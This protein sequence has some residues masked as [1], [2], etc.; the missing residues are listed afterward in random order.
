LKR[1]F[2]KLAL[3]GLKKQ[4]IPAIKLAGALF[5]M[6]GLAGC[7]PGFPIVTA[8]QEARE[9]KQT[10][11][12]KKVEY[13]LKETSKIKQEVGKAR[14]DTNAD[15]ELIR[16]EL[17]SIQG[18]FEEKEFETDRI[19][20][21]LDSL[22]NTL[23]SIQQRYASVEKEGIR[24]GEKRESL[25]ESLE[26]INATL[27]TLKN[28][29]ESMDEEVGTL[30]ESQRSI[31][32][33][34]DEL[35]DE[36]RQSLGSIDERLSRLEAEPPQKEKKEESI[37]PAALYMEGY[38]DTMDKNF[39]SAMETFRRFL[40]QFPDHELADNAQYWLGEIYYAGGDWERAILEFDK[41]VKKYPSGDKVADSLLKQGY[42]FEKLGDMKT[43]KILLNRVV[44]EFP[45]SDTAKKAKERLE[46]KK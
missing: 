25:N 30:R 14:A 32:S 3:K 36:F 11:Q 5:L 8:E 40:A 2:L 10:A 44:E 38:H 13:L 37:D 39:T 34:M 4:A 18:R 28:S 20:E 46:E 35:T 15:L 22:E 29:L 42:S 24:A 21:T 12:E 6:L 41:V 31:D 16:E 26:S 43:A 45:Q 17:S 9:K 27:D 33:A 7:G 19:T 23:K 1:R